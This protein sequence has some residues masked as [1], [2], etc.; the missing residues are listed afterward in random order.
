MPR[1]GM[2]RAQTQLELS[3]LTAE[4]RRSHA[5][6]GRTR[7]RAWWR[8]RSNSRSSRDSRRITL[9][10]CRRGAINLVA[11]TTRYRRGPAENR[12]VPCQ[13]SESPRRRV[14]TRDHAQRSAG[15]SIHAGRKMLNGAE[16]VLSRRTFAAVHSVRRRY[17]ARRRSLG[18][19]GTDESGKHL[20]AVWS[21]A[22]QQVETAWR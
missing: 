1:A 2:S 9:P 6:G 4:T 13:W 7:D 8:V 20:A 17:S 3:R 22:F 5:R 16:R 18:A 10:E 19:G 11:A 12:R 14:L 21:H 15:I